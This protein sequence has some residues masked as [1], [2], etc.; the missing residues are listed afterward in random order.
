MAF[1]ALHFDS[2]NAMELNADDVH[3]AFQ[4]ALFVFMIQFL[5]IFILAMIIF[6]SS[7]SF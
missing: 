3:D 7:G 6:G 1:K 4:S 2:M 5:L